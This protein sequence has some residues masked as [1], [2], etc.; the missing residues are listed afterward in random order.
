MNRINVS[1]F[2]ENY[3]KVDFD[4]RV[5]KSSCLGKNLKVVNS[6]V[7]RTSY[8]VKR[9]IV[10]EDDTWMYVDFCIERVLDWGLPVNIHFEK[11]KAEN[12]REYIKVINDDWANHEYTNKSITE[13]I[14][15]E[16]VFDGIKLIS[17]KYGEKIR[18]HVIEEDGKEV[19]YD[20]LTCFNRL[21]DDLKDNNYIINGKLKNDLSV[22]I[23]IIEKKNTAGTRSYAW[24]E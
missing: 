17:T 13:L 3:T 4:K 23:N 1:D 20:T 6:G 9:F 21:Y 24:Y 5:T 8:G 2:R 15:K 12:G 11:T 22:T 7:M 19:D 16:I 10:F 14:G 18:L